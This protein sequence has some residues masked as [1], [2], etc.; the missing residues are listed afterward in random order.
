MHILIILIEISSWPW[1]L[2]IF[3]ALIGLIILSSLKTKEPSLGWIKNIW[4]VES[5]LFFFK[6]VYCSG[7][8]YW[9]CLPLFSCQ[10]QISC[11]SKEEELAKFLCCYK[12]FSELTNTLL[13]VTDYIAGN[14]ELFN[15]FSLS[16][17]NIKI[18]RKI[19]TH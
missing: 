15:L 8:S 9:N 5:T 11:P 17:C 3:K 10:L 1:T 19:L 7:K 4:F 6:G 2:C 14:N 13:A 12:R 18:W 16:F